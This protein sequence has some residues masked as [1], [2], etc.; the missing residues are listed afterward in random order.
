[1]FSPHGIVINQSNFFDSVKISVNLTRRTLPSTVLFVLAAFLISKGLDL[2]WGVPNETSWLLLVGI[3]GHAFVT[4][5]L[6]ASSFVYYRDAIR[7]IREMV[8]LR[9]MKT[10]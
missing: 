9:E 5:G 1:V 2:L 6:V 8:K 4:T 3:F 10:I 7:W